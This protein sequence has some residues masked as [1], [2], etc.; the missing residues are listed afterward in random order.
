M[1]TLYTIGYTGRSLDDLAEFATLH[2][3]GIVDVRFSAWSRDPKW[4]KE[5]LQKSMEYRGVEYVHI[6]ELGNI[7]IDSPR[8]IE[9]ADPNGGC[10]DLYVLLE[11]S[12]QIILCAC[13]DPDRCHRSV[14]AQMMQERYGVEFTHLGEKPQKPQAAEVQGE[15][16]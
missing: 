2:R 4:R 12:P 3:A 16:F 13:A 8:P 6:R 10:M 5:S 9:I 7:H 15:L 11:R 1:N 14:V